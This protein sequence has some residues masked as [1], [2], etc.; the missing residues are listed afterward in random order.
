MKAITEVGDKL[1][2]EE[3]QETL[4]RVDDTGWFVDDADIDEDFDVSYK[5]YDITSSPNDFN[6]S[7]IV[8]F[9]EKGVFH[10]PGF[11]RNYVWDIKRASKLIESI[12]IG[13]PI[14]QIFLYEEKRNRYAVVDGQQRLMSI[15]FFRKMRF[16]RSAKRSEIR[17]KIA[18][19]GQLSVDLIN[20]DRYFAPFNLKLTK[21]D[22][23]SNSKFN[24]LNYDTL[25]EL[26]GVFDLRTIRNV[27]V[28]QNAPEEESDSSVFEIFSR[29]NSG[30][31]NLRPQEIRNSLHHSQFMEMLAKVNTNKIWRKLL[32][33][34]DLDLHEKDVEILLRC[35][36]LLVHGEAYREP[37]SRFLND[38]ARRSA[39]LDSADVRFIEDLLTKFFDSVSGLKSDSF[40]VG[41]K[42][43]RFGI[44]MFEAVFRVA[45]QDAYAKKTDK[46]RVITDDSLALIRKHKE[47]G[48]ATR[49]GAGHTSNVNKRF[50]IVR[51]ILDQAE[52]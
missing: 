12:L 30:G 48:I 9:I 45:C 21:R 4:D 1:D 43:S 14:P 34:Q 5:N 7:T 31:V 49:A 39:K 23:S 51:D 25:G 15:Y 24:R 36:G 38:F 8:D 18:R 46:I 40:K 13:L 33:K 32:G 35:V 41:G 37:M 11:Q 44:A 10:I 6:I 27:I 52:V 3:E 47:F 28:R 22:G 19:E 29:L 50:E 26:K 2:L 20:D 17:Q 16:P 42:A